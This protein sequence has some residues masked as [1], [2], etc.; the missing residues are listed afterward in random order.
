[1]NA[2]IFFGSMSGQT[3]RIAQE[4]GKKLG[5]DLPVKD[6][7]ETDP[8]EFLKYDFL[9]LGTSTWDV[10][11]IVPDWEMFFKQLIP[12]SLKGKKVALYGLGDQ[13]A[14]P[15]TFADGLGILAVEMEKAG[16]E[17]VVPWK[18]EDYLFARSYALREDGFAGL[19]IDEDNQPERS[20]QRLVKWTGLLMPFLHPKG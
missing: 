7:A 9:I 20:E 14:Y 19:V 4:I 18:N 8:A 5:M 2:G 17:L 12:G 1:M 13:G 16:A 6:I 15:D 10:G 3:G 11:K